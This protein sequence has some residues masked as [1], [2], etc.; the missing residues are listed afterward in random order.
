MTIYY[1]RTS[2]NQFGPLRLA[3]IRRFVKDGVFQLSDQYLDFSSVKWK[4]MVEDPVL[5]QVF[6]ENNTDKKPPK[7][8][9]IASGK[10][11]VGKTALAASMSIELANLEKKVIL[12]DA[13]F[14]GPD[15]HEWMGISRPP[16][17]LNA[18]FSKK[19]LSLSDILLSTPYKNIK[20]IC[21]D[22]GSLESSNPK[23]FQRLKFIRQL[24]QLDADY[25]LVDQSPG[26][27]Y[28]TV[29]IYLN[30]DE[31]II[32]T[33]PEATSY[34]DAF[35]F[36]RSTLIR[37]LKK[38]IFFSEYALQ[39]LEE[40]ENLDWRK[41]EKSLL[42][43]L[44][45]IERDNTRAGIIFKG[46][47]RNFHPKIVTN[48]VQNKRESLESTRFQYSLTKLLLIEARHLG[49]IEYRKDFRS[50]LK[51]HRPFVLIAQKDADSLHFKKWRRTLENGLH[52]LAK[53]GAGKKENNPTTKE[54][55]QPAINHS[56]EIHAGVK[57]L[58][59]QIPS[60]V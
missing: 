14:G 28:A 35:N 23:Y 4:A 57:K 46:V 43:F 53:I 21:G 33:L 20:M 38:A 41:Y 22:V 51:E 12:V 7:I 1:A 32:V 48:M 54:L 47:L 25:V 55:L 52:H 59:L 56:H 10:G 13:D 50:T 2:S 15:L 30:C 60:T 45:R 3:E 6:R 17:T 5:K 39:Q 49:F 18:L 40:F 16:I 11:G 29:D 31:G 42:P 19:G 24:R 58:N 36:I 27:S 37:R 26:V 34:M 8:I 9:A 44:V